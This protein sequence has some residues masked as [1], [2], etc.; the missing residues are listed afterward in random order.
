MD[1]IGGSTIVFILAP[2]DYAEVVDLLAQLQGRT[3]HAELWR[4]LLARD[5]VTRMVRMPRAHARDFY[6]LLRDHAD[7][8]RASSGVLENARAIVFDRVARTVARALGLPLSDEP[9]S[10]S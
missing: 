10:R 8:T 2:G 7:V 4:T 6:H 9:E 3:T 5:P 1:Q